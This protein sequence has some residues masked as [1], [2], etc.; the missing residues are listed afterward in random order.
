MNGFVLLTL[1]LQNELKLFLFMVFTVHLVAR[2]AHSASNGSS[3]IALLMR[4][5]FE[6]AEDGGL[7]K[8]EYL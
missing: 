7:S 4:D 1:F 6:E 2:F 5:A 8:E 3:I